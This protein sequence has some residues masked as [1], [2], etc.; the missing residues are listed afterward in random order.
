M[1]KEPIT[2]S[3]LQNLKSELE[4]LKKIDFKKR[5]GFFLGSSIGNF[6]DKKEKIFLQ[7]SEEI[8]P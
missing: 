7:K 6:Y 5:I 1:E 2:V 8:C 4:D 3:G